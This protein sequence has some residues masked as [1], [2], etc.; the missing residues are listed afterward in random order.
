MIPISLFMAGDILFYNMVI[1]EE[2]FSIL[3][4]CYCTVFKNDWQQAGHD[5][6]EP[7]TIE[8]LTEQAQKIE[9]QE[10]GMI[11][12]RHRSDGFLHSRSLSVSP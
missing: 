2:G 8:M 6:G 5:C 10:I 3:W 1:G 9:N 7:W 4:C 11:G 12:G